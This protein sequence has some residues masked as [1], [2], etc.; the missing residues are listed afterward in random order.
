MEG[1]KVGIMGPEDWL[2]AC[3][4]KHDFG[5][6]IAEEMGLKYGKQEEFR[7]KALADEIAARDAARLPDNPLDWVPPPSDPEFARRMRD[8]MQVGFGS[9]YNWVNYGK[10]LKEDPFAA[11]GPLDS[12][13]LE[14]EQRRRVEEWNQRYLERNP[15]VK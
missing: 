3:A 8:R 12:A 13:A 5:Y 10:S 4:Q 1:D 6:Q 9:V 14:A 15:G 7:L 2:D 11:N